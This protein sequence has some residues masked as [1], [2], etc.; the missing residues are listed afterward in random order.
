MYVFCCTKEAHDVIRIVKRCHNIQLLD[1][2]TV[3]N[4]NLSDTHNIEYIQTLP[5]SLQEYRVSLHSR[6][7]KVLKKR[8]GLLKI[9]EM[10]IY[11]IFV[12]IYY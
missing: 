12:V 2:G 7:Q 1:H 9:C 11:G 8:Q 3:N 5:K 6:F 4:T 10:F